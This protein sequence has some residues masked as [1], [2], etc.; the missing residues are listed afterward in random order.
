M[1]KVAFNKLNKVKSIPDIVYEWEGNDL[2]IKQYLPL[3]KKLDIIETV[4]S[5]SGNGEE[6]FFNI[7]K[8]QTFYTIEMLKNYT[9]ISF[10]EKQEEDPA[11]LY[12]GILLNHIWEVLSEQIPER[13]RVYIWDNILELAHRV[14][15]YNNSVLGIIKAVVANKETLELDTTELFNN[16]SD[17][18]KLETVRQLF[19]VTG[20]TN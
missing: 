15:E 7:I 3:E 8:L 1:A 5:L 11:K 9:N 19:D 10:T 12:D 4:I 20:L 16:I 13:E 2:V 17:P 18:E 14:T 6:G